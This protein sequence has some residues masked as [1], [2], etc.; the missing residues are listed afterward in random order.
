MNVSPA[1]ADNMLGKD[2]RLMWNLTIQFR[3]KGAYYRNMNREEERLPKYKEYV[4]T[5]L[6]MRRT[7]PSTQDVDAR[8]ARLAELRQ[9]VA[10]LKANVKEVE[11]RTPTLAQA[12]AQYQ[13]LVD[14]CTKSDEETAGT[15]WESLVREDNR[16]ILKETRDL[17][18][19]LPD[20]RPREEVVAARKLLK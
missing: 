2:V 20:W 17:I 14:K 7:M 6:K 4:D 15:E 10:D 18:D 13:V 12:K 1:D 5:E 8:D 16:R 9:K 19:K 11:R 3:C